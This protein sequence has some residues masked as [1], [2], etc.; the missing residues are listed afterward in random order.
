MGKMNCASD[1]TAAFQPPPP[2]TAVYL[3][4]PVL[5]KER[6][7]MTSACLEFGG[8]YDTASGAVFHLPGMSAIFTEQIAPRLQN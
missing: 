8:A 4:F 1:K 2:F 3:Y 5:L 6:A 7:R